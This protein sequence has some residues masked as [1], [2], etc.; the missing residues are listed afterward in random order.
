VTIYATTSTSTVTSYT[1]ASNVETISTACEATYTTTYAAKCAPTNLVGAINDVGLVSGQY[2]DGTAVS[3][4]P[5]V[6]D[7][8]Y[9]HDPSL[10]CQLCQN[11][12]GCGASM[13]G[14]GPGACGLYYAP[15]NASVGGAEC[16][17]FV[18][19][20]GTEAGRI[21]GESLVI[22]SGCGLIEYIGPEP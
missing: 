5:D 4:G 13:W 8:Q 1:V 21:A 19:S 15:A 11:N 18:L 22:Q 2:A 9:H 7:D 3:Y 20:F 16:G 14:P 6:D 17:E 10:C 12:A